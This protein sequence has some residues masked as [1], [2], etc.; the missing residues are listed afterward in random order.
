MRILTGLLMVLLC[1]A[2]TLAGESG[3]VASTGQFEY[4]VSGVDVAWK[5]GQKPWMQATVGFRITNTSPAP[6]RFAIIQSWPTLQLEG[7]AVHFTLR[8][9][10]ISGIVWSL[11]NLIGAC[12]EHAENFTM[13]RPTYSVTGSLVLDA[14]AADQDIA[15]VKHA[16]LSATLMVQSLDDKKC[17]IEP[18]SVDDIPVGV[19]L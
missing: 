15:L 1:C 17:W 19:H 13:L 3:A 8:S 16:R 18:F 6:V 14:Y 12:S 11:N 5:P 10:G 7:A 4:R 9:G 2:P